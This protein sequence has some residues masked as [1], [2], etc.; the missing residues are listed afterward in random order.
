MDKGGFTPFPWQVN[1][2]GIADP[3]SNSGLDIFIDASPY[4]VL[5]AN[6]AQ[7]ENKTSAILRGNPDARKR[8][9]LIIL[10]KQFK[11][12]LWMPA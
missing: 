11:K 1:S 8:R 10:R 9:I 7:A 6:N 4:T 12:C 5:P 3:Y 2:A